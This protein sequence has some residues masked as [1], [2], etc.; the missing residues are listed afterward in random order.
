MISNS[1]PDFRSAI[2]AAGMT[3]PDVIEPGQFHRFPG[4]GKSNGNTAGWCKLFEDER[5]GSYGDFS[6]DM[7]E[8]WQAERARSLAPSEREAFKRTVAEA[9]AVA[10]AARKQEQNEAALDAQ[11]TWD[12]ATVAND[13]HGYVKRKGVSTHGV[14][15]YAGNR[16]IAGM[17][18]E[19]ALLVPCRNADGEL[20]SVQFIAPERQQDGSDKRYLPRGERGGLYHAIGTPNGVMCVCE[21][22]A[23]GASIHEATGYAV[24]IAFD[25]GNLAAVAS[26]LRE[27][28]PESRIIVCADDD[29]RTQP[30][31]GIEKATKAAQAVGAKLAVPD[32]G[33]DRPDGATDFND[34]HKHRGAQ[35]VKRCIDAARAP[36]VSECQPAAQTTTRGDLGGAR[37][38]MVRGDSIQPE[39]HRW[40]WKEWLARG[41]LHI[42][43]GTAGTGKTTLALAMGATVTSGGRWPDGSHCEPG[44][45]V[46]WSGE[47]D[48][49]DTL[50][51]RLLAMGADV[52]RMYFVGAVHDDRGRRAFDPATDVALLAER[53]QECGPVSLLIV[54]PVVSAVAA[55]SHKNGE[56][57]RGLQ[58]LVNI[59]ALHACA[60]LGITHYSKST[61]GRDPLERVTGSLA[62]GALPRIVMGTAKPTEARAMRRL[63]RAKSNIGPDG[64]GFDYD[65]RQVEL[66]GKPGLFASSV[67][68]GDWIDGTARELLAEVEIEPESGERDA[69][70][71]AAGFLRSL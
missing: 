65:L 36:D 21:G 40:I 10:D 51:P 2:V 3:P 50:I 41:K 47:D 66:D 44:N 26:V 22:Y 55:D 14:R 43:A 1:M 69:L 9:R 11:R 31:T 15:V 39:C 37:V 28:Y 46:I 45:V 61:S 49:A 34:L 54:D 70:D 32:F 53:L 62:F 30:N 58:P 60:L 4:I 6:I 52:S 25:A 59:A 13:D 12:S 19:G 56:V 17:N 29:Y 57:R 42:L 33:D 64:G 20:R 38:S 35:S 67:S 68:W 18:C 8:T 7:H 24:A 16:V 5:G 63:V 23:T 48:P 71:E 27:K